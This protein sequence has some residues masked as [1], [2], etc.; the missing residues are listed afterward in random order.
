MTNF[1]RKLLGETM[2]LPI[3]EASAFFLE[4]RSPVKTAS[5]RSGMSKTAGWQDPPDESGVLEGQ[6]E[7]PVEHAV[8]LMGNTAQNLLR[9][10][11]AGLIYSNSIRGQF[12]SDVK[13]ALRCNEWDH[14]TAFEYLVERMTVLAGPPH[15]PDPEMPPPS[16]NPL[17]VA[18]RMIRA[19]QEM[20]HAYQELC[21]VLGKN[22]MKDRI[23]DF[24]GRCQKHLDAL[25]MALPQD[26]GSKPMDPKP[27]TMM[28]KREGA[29]T[30]EQEAEE[31]EEFQLAEETMGVEPVE[32]GSK[33]TAAV[34]R[35]GD[36]VAGM[37]KWAKDESDDELKEKGRQR[38]V[39]NI[40]AEHGR[41]KARRGERTGKVMGTIAGL[42]TGAAAGRKF[43]GGRA[44]TIAGMV[45][46]GMA[47]RSLGGE[48][49]TEI[50]IARAKTAMAK[51]AK[52]RGWGEAIG[53]TAGGILGGA[54]G[55]TAGLLAGTPT[56][57]GALALS[58]AGMTA[59]GMAGEALGSRLGRKVD[60]MN[61]KIEPPD[62]F[63]KAAA[64]MVQWV[65]LAQDAPMT[66]EAPMA[67]PT[68][69]QQLAPVHYMQA[70]LVGQELQN[71]NEANFHKARAEQIKQ[72]AEQMV[73]Q[74]TQQAQMA[75]QQAQAVMAEN[76]VADQKVE[77][78]F[79]MAEQAKAEALAKTEA[80][81]RERIG[82]M[83][84]RAKLL[85][86][87]SSDPVAASAT[88]MAA[89]PAPPPQAGGPTPEE[90]AMAQA[91]AAQLP[92]EA[93][94]QAQEAVRSEAD[95]A[96]QAAQAQAAIAT[97]PGM[98]VMASAQIPDAG[99]YPP[100][101]RGGPAGKAPMP[102]TA[103]GAGPAEGADDMNENAGGA[104]GF[105]RDTAV[106]SNL[107]KT[108]GPLGLLGGGLV[109]AGSGAYAIRK[110]QKE[111]VDPALQKVHQLESTQDGTFGNAAALARA[112]KDVIDRELTQAHPGQTML[113]RAA[114]DT[115][116][117]AVAGSALENNLRYL[118]R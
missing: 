87:A 37:V 93:G 19:E 43:I 89:P 24:A 85:E 3:H 10:M 118:M 79:Q 103:P 8:N 84:M 68:D 40:A 1:E 106:S 42:G 53:S 95:A 114:G 98:E 44:G 34:A 65:K 4:V 47:G 9:L 28:A 25:W 72:Q 104:P 113:R 22:P 56:G 23:K 105:D 29:E 59:G 99:L 96:E 82:T 80:A 107:R 2:S 100:P 117:G 58:G 116:R 69:S 27:A 101:G 76:A 74:A 54:G 30:P 78:A 102:R 94:E 90:Q 57:P 75:T 86:I 26:Y 18:E 111:G 49:G 88:N 91:E 17:D 51:I 31:S 67:S 81:A 5:M 11:S 33:K 14:K 38:A 46:G 77:Q 41:E 55:A 70:E 62:E 71:Q 20:L 13:N 108:A 63:R 6:F 35:L 21:A 97:E 50:D 66:A 52:E 39:A 83:D 12:A 60:Q 73:Q 36:I 64:A 15:I 115:M 16:T 112:R 109:G 45:G 92:G 48:L 7:V 110:Q 32:H 61:L